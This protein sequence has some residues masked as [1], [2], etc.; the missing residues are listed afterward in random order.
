M[1][2]MIIIIGAPMISIASG[3]R[4][5]ETIDLPPAFASE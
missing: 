3:M 1:V 2:K 4:M 5:W